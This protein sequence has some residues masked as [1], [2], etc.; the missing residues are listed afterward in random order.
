MILGRDTGIWTRVLGSKAQD[1]GPLHYVST[2]KVEGCRSWEPTHANHGL[3]TA[4]VANTLVIHTLDPKASWYICYF[5]LRHSCQASLAL[6]LGINQRLWPIIV[7][8]GLQYYFA[9]FIFLGQDTVDSVL[10]PLPVITPWGGIYNFLVAYDIPTNHV[11]KLDW[12]LF[13]YFLHCVCLV[14]VAILDVAFHIFNACFDVMFF[15]S[16]SY[17]TYSNQVYKG[18]PLFGI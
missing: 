17:I 1:D 2:N 7:R 6:T 18:L 13:I 11:S 16:F 10:V 9:I 12:Y 8:E 3:P 14:C 15:S 4:C 5:A